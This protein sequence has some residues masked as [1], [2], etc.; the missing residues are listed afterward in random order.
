MTIIYTDNISGRQIFDYEWSHD[1]SRDII[2][3]ISGC[4]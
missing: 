2:N 3:T 4:K 1:A